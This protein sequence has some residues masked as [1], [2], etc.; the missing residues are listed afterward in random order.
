MSLRPTIRN[1]RAAGMTVKG[2]ANKH[3]FQY[4]TI[5]KVLHGHTGKRRIGTTLEILNQLK[6]DG[7]LEEDA[8]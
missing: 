1:I 6:K 3:G 7:Y 2:W 8:A 5:I 4:Q